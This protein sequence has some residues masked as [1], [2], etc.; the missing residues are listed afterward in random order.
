M[1]QSKGT[2]K[3]DG[4]FGVPIYIH[5]STLLGGLLPS[6]WVGFGIQEIIYFTIGFVILVAV[7][8]FGH[9]IAAKAVGLK[10]LAVEMSVA[11]GLCRYE[12]TLSIGK[13]LFVT[14]AGLLAQFLLLIISMIYAALIGDEAG[15]AANCLLF[16]FTFINVLMFVTNIIPARVLS[17]LSTD[18]FVLWKLGMVYIKSYF[19]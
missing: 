9:V 6:A 15:P 2:L 4:P 13:A 8:E 17:G 14:S 18:G 5:W 7:H 12:W 3:I 16:V 19:Q 1:T 11:G 10:V